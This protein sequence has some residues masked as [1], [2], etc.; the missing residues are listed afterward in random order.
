MH[1][2]HP[3]LAVGALIAF[4]L[5]SVQVYAGGPLLLLLPGVP[6]LWPNGGRMIPFNPDLGG[7]GPLTNA[8]AVAQSTAAFQVW[9][10]VAS[11]SATHI[12]AGQLPVDVDETNFVPYSLTRRTGWTER[13]RLRRRTAR[14]SNLLVRPRLRR[15]RLRGSGVDRPRR[16][17]PSSKAWRS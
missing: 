14:S 11:A 17:A 2:R 8:Q 5:T 3:V 4:M 7:L 9:A 10:D 12:N 16:P 15:A 13:D 6:F 1:K